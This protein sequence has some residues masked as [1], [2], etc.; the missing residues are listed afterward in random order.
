MALRSVMKYID[1]VRAFRPEKKVYIL[2]VFMKQKFAIVCSC[3]RI[4][5][6]MPIFFISTYISRKKASA[7]RGINGDKPISS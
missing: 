6:T 7:S 2:K 3:S 5:E 1:T 4:F